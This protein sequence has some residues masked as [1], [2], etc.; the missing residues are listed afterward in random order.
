VQAHLLEEKLKE[1]IYLDLGISAKTFS[2]ETV[3]NCLEILLEEASA[4]EKGR[5]IASGHRSPD[6]TLFNYLSSPLRLKQIA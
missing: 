6:N 5:L 1:I 4:R 2:R 3:T